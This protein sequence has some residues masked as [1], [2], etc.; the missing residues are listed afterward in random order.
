MK[1][2]KYNYVSFFALIILLPI[3]VSISF[4]GDIT[5]DRSG[6]Y[7]DN[8][9]LLTIPLSLFVCLY[10]VLKNIL[11]IFKKTFFTALFLYFIL[12]ILLKFIYFGLDLQMI[13]VIIMMLVFISTN[14][15][16]YRY[17]EKKISLDNLKNSEKYFFIYPLLA[18]LLVS[19]IGYYF[20]NLSKDSFISSEIKVYSYSQYFAYMFVLLLGS[21]SKSNFLFFLCLPLVL[22][23][24]Y[25]T[26]NDTALILSM[27]LTF[28][29]LIDKLRRNSSKFFLKRSIIVAI[30][31]SVFVYFFYMFYLKNYFLIP[32]DNLFYR[33][34]VIEKYIAD[35]K[36]IQILFPFLNNGKIVNTSLHNEFLEVFNATGYIGFFLYYYFIIS[37]FNG[38]NSLFRVQSIAFLLVIILGGLLVEPTLH[39]YTSIAL[40][41]YSALYCSISNK[42]SYESKT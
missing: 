38:F 16:F 23:I 10:L 36:T 28:Y 22:L 7:G 26:R 31:V 27:I 9:W 8:L 24:S 34:V 33:Q 37:C 25:I 39:L 21:S 29:F 41:Y 5:L 12:I 13:K 35:F 42:M 17:F 1:I 30:F 32:N 18:I 20:F 14:Y 6:G 11:Y 15:A 2:L 3:F 4:N 19:I 40:S